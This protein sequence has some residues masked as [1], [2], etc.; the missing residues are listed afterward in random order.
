MTLRTHYPREG[1]FIQVVAREIDKAREAQL[2]LDR[3]VS[4]METMKGYGEEPGS[5]RVSRDLGERLEYLLDLGLVEIDESLPIDTFVVDQ[6]GGL[7]ERMKMWLVDI[8]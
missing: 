8:R 5:A 2:A 6:G 3:I 7:E 4:E 1:S